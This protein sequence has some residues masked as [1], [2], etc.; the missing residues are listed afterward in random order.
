MAVLSEICV[1][2]ECPELSGIDADALELL[3][4]HVDALTRLLSPW[5]LDDRATTAELVRET[6]RR[7]SMSVESITDPAAVWPWLRT[8]ASRVAIDHRR[9]TPRPTQAVGRGETAEGAHATVRGDGTGH[10]EDP[11]VALEPEHRRVAIELFARG[12]T[13]A[14]VARVLGMAE[15]DVSRRGYEALRALRAAVRDHAPADG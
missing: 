6:L 3:G 11:A 4:A 7:A 12:R 15:E 5:T 1:E 14:Q 10:G 13:V 2:V 9:S 8:L